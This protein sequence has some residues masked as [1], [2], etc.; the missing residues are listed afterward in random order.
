MSAW[1]PGGASLY[2]NTWAGQV[3]QHGCKAELVNIL[4]LVPLAR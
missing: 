2:D 3:G 1:L 4:K